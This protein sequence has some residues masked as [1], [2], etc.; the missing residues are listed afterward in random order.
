MQTIQILFAGMQ[1]RCRGEHS[2][3]K[4]EQK[5][6]TYQH[7]MFNANIWLFIQP[8]IWY[9]LV[10][11]FFVFCS[12]FTVSNNM[13]WCKVY[14]LR[15]C[16]HPQASVSTLYYNS[17]LR[18]TTLHDGWI[19]FRMKRKYRI[20]MNVNGFV[21][22]LG[23][24]YSLLRVIRQIWKPNCVLKACQI[25]Q[26]D[27]SWMK[28]NWITVCVC[29]FVCETMNANLAISTLED[30]VTDQSLNHKFFL[31]FNSTRSATV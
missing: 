23:K 12:R 7:I 5:A 2:L 21:F 19:D 17:T 15:A 11:F 10:N 16:V 3:F 4:S 26:Y 13:F 6:A 14:V 24:F 27:I 1:C 18:Y 31:A 8:N 25:C 29:V 30:V 20:R 28:M 22:I 9:R